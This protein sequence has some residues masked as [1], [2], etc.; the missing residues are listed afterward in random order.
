M[1]AK[2]AIAAVTLSIVAPAS[3]QLEV[4]GWVEI[5]AGAGVRGHLH[6]TERGRAAFDGTHIGRGRY[7]AAARP[8][9]STGTT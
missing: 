2:V 5:D 8:R 7:P 3:A 6:V 1:R 9:A 4:S